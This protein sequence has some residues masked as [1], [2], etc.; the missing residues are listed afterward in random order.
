MLSMAVV[1]DS[2]VQ[3]DDLDCR[4][5]SVDL[6]RFCCLPGL[7]RILELKNELVN[8]EFSEFQF[9]DDLVL[10][11]KLTPVGIKRTISIRN[12]L[13]EKLLLQSL[14]SQLEE[15]LTLSD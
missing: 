13:L 12:G 9:L 8:L 14:H 11:M 6:A 1:S 10:D 7:C 4:Y 5:V 15:L 2:Y 3:P